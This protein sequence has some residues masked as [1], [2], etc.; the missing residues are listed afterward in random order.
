MQ[1]SHLHNFR[2]Y[3]RSSQISAFSKNI[4]LLT[5]ISPHTTCIRAAVS[6]PVP[7]DME[8][9][10]QTFKVALP[11]VQE[12]LSDCSF[13]SFDCEMTGLFLNS[14]RR[15]AYL[16]E[17]EDRYEE[18]RASA[19]SFIIN[20]FG[21]SAFTWDDTHSTWIAKTFNFYV[22]PRGSEEIKFTCQASSLEFLSQCN[23][24]FNKWIYDG[25][26]YTTI[27]LRDARLLA[28][29]A[30]RKQRDDIVVSKKEDVEFVNETVETV[31]QWLASD[32]SAPLLLCS[33]N[34]YQR[35]LQWQNLRKDQFGAQIFPGFYVERS[36]NSNGKPALL[37]TKA[38]P[39]EI[40][41][42]EADE[43]ARQ[44]AIIHDEAGFA[45]VLEAMK[46]S[47][48]PAVGHN[49][50]F[51]VA[52]SMHSFASP[53]PSTWGEYKSSVAE[54]FPAGVFDTKY[55]AGALREELVS[56]ATSED[57]ELVDA[58]EDTGLGS[59]FS[60]LKEK[61]SDHVMHAEG[62][63]RYLGSS[64]FAHEAGYDAYMTGSVFTRL[65][66]ATQRN[67][68]GYV[69]FDKD[70]VGMSSYK[71]KINISRSDLPYLALGS[72][73]DAPIERQHVFYLCN[74]VRGF[75][76]R[77]GD[78]VKLIHVQAPELGAVRLHA[79]GDSNNAVLVD[80]VDKPELSLEGSIFILGKLF[81]DCHVL[82]YASYSEE[83]RLARKSTEDEGGRH[84]SSGN[85]T[86]RSA[87]GISKGA[88]LEEED[89]FQRIKIMQAE[90][91]S[92]N[93]RRWCSIM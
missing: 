76:P 12:A 53:L 45:A 23:F 36:E 30:E 86:R 38:S 83:K 88:R 34:S 2:S 26:P 27:A 41:Q 78:M 85:R 35:A 39:E 57:D 33:A 29:D 48:K 70:D 18:A 42:K 90:G 55:I 52:Y 58:L 20:Q 73:P 11:V 68:A 10:R 5:S 16:D 22:F 56:R 61:Y 21:L 69:K 60:S 93:G 91:L 65:L 81:P 64:D 51:D 28:L 54:W 25:I 79:V 14:R 7:V 17:S 19:S 8:V 1:A 9:T 87:S 62:Y 89:P 72:L 24:D 50:A 46:N 4:L 43:R 40:A 32:T 44:L 49:L 47:N 74:F 13:F 63:E 75:S 6:A 84:F 92:D 59:L 31:K 82:P 66:A 3:F 67:E 37:V 80:C 71:N 15:N 77:I